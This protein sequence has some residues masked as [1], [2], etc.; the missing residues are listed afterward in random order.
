MNSKLTLRQ[1]SLKR[2]LMEDLAQGRI[3]RRQFLTRLL[4]A[5]FSAP[6]VYVL[7]GEVSGEQVASAQ[8]R[9]TPQTIP[10]AQANV[11]YAEV[12]TLS[13]KLARIAS[14]PTVVEMMRKI[15]QI[16]D[17]AQRQREA[18]QFVNKMQTDTGFRTAVGV[19]RDF[20]ITTRVFEDPN[21][22]R[23]LAGPPSPAA[24]ARM[25]APFEAPSARIPITTCMSVGL[26]VCAS[27]GSTHE[28]GIRPSFQ[29]SQ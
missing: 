14:D 3:E 11:A 7:L 24:A 19:D 1:E 26:V 6:A 21:A 22:A 23:T 28:V 13:V 8:A 20:R 25:R 15:E 5:G 27:V 16:K 17:P 4:T 9:P 29:P 18:E 12:Q 2:S 10:T